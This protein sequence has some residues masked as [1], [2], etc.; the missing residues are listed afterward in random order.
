[1]SKTDWFLHNS[2]KKEVVRPLLTTAL[3]MFHQEKILL[4]KERFH[5]KI[6]NFSV[7]LFRTFDTNHEL[8]FL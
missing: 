2:N 6:K 7:I 5:R 3:C 8:A 4:I 1:M